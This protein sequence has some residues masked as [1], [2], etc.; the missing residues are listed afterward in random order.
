MSP[1]PGDKETQQPDWML[2]TSQSGWINPPSFACDAK[3]LCH[4]WRPGNQTR[5]ANT[6]TFIRISKLWHTNSNCILCVTSNGTKSV[7]HYSSH[8]LKLLTHTMKWKNTNTMHQTPKNGCFNKFFHIY[9][10][11]YQGTLN[12]THANPHTVKNMSIP[13]VI[14]YSRAMLRQKLWRTIGTDSYQQRY[15]SSHPHPFQ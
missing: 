7:R 10:H 15:P 13:F 4:S 11:W 5:A 12:I 1:H 6:V 8:T 14:H 3:S 2:S 9:T